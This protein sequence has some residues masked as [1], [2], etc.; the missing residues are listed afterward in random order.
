MRIGGFVPFTL[1]DYPEH[2]SAVVF[3]QG[4]CWHC[5]Y[6]HNPDLIDI[7]NKIQNAPS[8]DDI[9]AFLNKR[10]GL[11]DAIVFSGGEP[12][13]QP[14]LRH[15]EKQVKEVGF[16]AVL[17]TNGH[18]PALLADIL[19][20]LQWVGLDIKAPFT[21]YHKAVFADAE[22]QDKIKNLNIG[23]E[24]EKSLNILLSSN[25]DFE[26][27]TTLDP[28]ILN[29]DMLREIAGCL[30]GK[31]VKTYAI[32]KYRK[33]DDSDK[34]PSDKEINAFFDDKELLNELTALFPNFIV[35]Q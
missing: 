4:C 20:E 10:I 9:L 27:R 23:K 13:L 21:V 30:S 12:I 22:R 28:R 18:N 31:G 16:A 7:N 5:P 19:P 34:Q 32:Q 8:W 25:V 35:R 2:I 26:C 11:L 15:A 6:C 29:K 17:H 14:Y 1:V 3:C 33:T 24:V